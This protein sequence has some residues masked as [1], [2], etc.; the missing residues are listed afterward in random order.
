MKNNFMALNGLLCQCAF[1][2]SFI[3]SLMLKTRAFECRRNFPLK[4]EVVPHKK[5]NNHMDNPLKSTFTLME[6]GAAR[7]DYYLLSM[8]ENINLLLVL[9]CIMLLYSQRFNWLTNG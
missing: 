3:H 7:I 5:M 8:N 2:P 4:Q 9:F 6:E 1:K